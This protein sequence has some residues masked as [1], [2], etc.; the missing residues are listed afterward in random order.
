MSS[1]PEIAAQTYV[2]AWQE[3]DAAARDRLIEACFAVD[4]RIVSLR[5]WVTLAS[6]F[7]ATLPAGKPRPRRAKRPKRER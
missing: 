6:R 1:S 7:V 5:A 4:G 3:P 2:A